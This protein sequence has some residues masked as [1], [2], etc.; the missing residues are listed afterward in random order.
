M[1][2]SVIKYSDLIG[3]D[4]TFDI[5]FQNIEQLKKELQELA[6]IL[7]GKLDIVNPNDEA[8][9]QGLVK[10]T[11]NLANAMKK[12]ETEEKKARTSKKKLNELTN[13][14]LIQ[15]E[16]QKIANRERVQRAKQMAILTN[17]ESGEIEKLRAK[18]SLT[19]LEWKKLSKEE[20]NNTKKGKQLIKTKKQLTDQ[21]KKL[22]KQTGDNRR[23]VGNYAASL[24]KLGK[25]AAGIFV[26]R[27]IAGAV[28][29][30]GAAF[31][32]L[33]EDNKETNAS[34]KSL[35]D[36]VENLK[37]GFVA[38]GLKIIEFVAEP[39]KNIISGL[40]F[41]TEN[42]LGFSIT[43]KK[44]SETVQDLQ[45]AFNSE[46]ETLKRGNLSNE[47]RKQLIEDINK[48]YKDYLP[49]LLTEKS[50][51]DEITNAQNTANKAFERKILLFASEEM[52]VDITKQRLKL[53]REQVDLE[54]AAN[55]TNAEAIK[56]N[57][58]L[59]TAIDMK[60]NRLIDGAITRQ[61]IAAE[62]N[63]TA[64]TA[65]RLNKEKLAQL[66][67]EQKSIKDILA[68]QGL[69]AKDFLGIEKKKTKAIK[70]TEKTKVKVFKDNIAERIKAV[71]SLQD[72]IQK[73][74]ASNEE[75]KTERLLALEEVRFKALQ[76]QREKDF[77]KYVA[78]V[79]KQEEFLIDFYGENSDEV[80]AFR[81]QAGEE[82]LRVETIMQKLSE[83]Q[84][85]ASEDKKNKI[86]DDSFKAQSE[87]TIKA[88]D[89]ELEE[90]DEQDQKKAKKETDAIL[91]T[92]GWRSEEE[93]KEIEFQRKLTDM[94]LDNIEDANEKKIKIQREAFRREREDI[95]ANEK[96]TREQRDKLIEQLDEKSRQYEASLSKERAKE[97]EETMKQ[98][99]EKVSQVVIDVFEKAAENLT[100]LVEEQGDAVEE[101]KERAEKGLSNTLAFEQKQLAEREAEQIRAEKRAKNAAEVMALYNLVSAHAMSGDKNALTRGLIDWSILKA[102]SEALDTGFEEGGWTGDYGTK[103]VAG[104][105][106]GKEYVVTASD[107]AKYGLAGKSG[108]EFGEAMSDY[109]YSPLQQNLYPSQNANF[110]KGLNNQQKTYAS[111]E[112]EVKAMRKAFEDSKNNDFDILQ[113]TDYFV[114]I[115]KRV[116]NNRMTKVNKQRKRL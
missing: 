91:R 110:K 112:N 98:V 47:A 111:L 40:N 92:I 84:L 34:A 87:A 39:L 105:V 109:F 108:A 1:A 71:E 115:S 96:Y 23:N 46:I 56:K 29:R 4:D 43:G 32:R 75:D 22:E 37:E 6:T 33:L 50:S 79:E 51:L 64:Q 36:T 59:T 63:N 67:E 18:L 116:T 11:E 93:K 26:G 17:K 69:S 113:M 70:K 19:T 52:M 57:N 30:I 80:I 55:K 7:K 62:N 81:T 88:Y 68:L 20:L 13:E 82:L 103:Q 54:Q 95:L 2:D 25:V 21:L 31:G 10:E 73:L 12:L 5:I 61:K 45:I 100:K 85:K 16:K 66:D 72:K 97:L 58:Q 104:V 78:L 101:Q 3:Q 9:M 106:H 41:V 94:E 74:E 65:L 38:L 107:V 86:I 49:N 44:A 89:I 28:R 15:R 35:F 60:D 83:E 102:L 8:Q 42:L 24:G 76:K 114:E 48:K 14:E 27:N 90:M 99:T 53:L 77:D